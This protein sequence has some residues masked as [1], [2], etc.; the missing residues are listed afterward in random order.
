MWKLKL[1]D[2]V[3][4]IEKQLGISK[5]SVSTITRKLNQTK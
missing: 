1:I 3:Q 2:T 5:I 4:S